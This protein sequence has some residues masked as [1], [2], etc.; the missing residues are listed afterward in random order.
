MRLLPLDHQY[1][2]NM[3]TKYLARAN[4]DPRHD[5]GDY[6]VGD[7]RA[8]FC[9]TW[10]FPIV[11]SYSDGVDAAAGYALNR[12]TFVYHA[13]ASQNASVSVIGT[14]ATLSAPIPLERI[15]C[16]GLA[17]PYWA[18]TVAVPKGGEYTY[19]YL[20]DGAPTLDPINPQR[21]TL[22]NG[23]EWSRFF[24][25][26]CTRRVTFERWEAVLLTRLTEHILPFRTRDGQRFID[27][28][29]SDLDRSAKDVQFAHAY[30]L[31]QNVGVVNFLDKAL[32]REESHHVADYRICLREVDRL[33]RQRNPF[34]D[35]GEMPREMF[36]DL[37]D[38]MAANRVAGW[39]YGRYQNPRYFLQLLR[40][41]C[42]TG[43]FAHPKYGG[44]AGGTGWA[45]LEDRYRDAAGATLFAW[46]ESIE[47][48][49]G[50][51]AEYRG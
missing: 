31:E 2:L 1:V 42:I 4:V 3:S 34:V 37:Y 43:A 32:A 38:E 12:V 46:R 9:E 16:D 6:A 33:L 10:R 50:D 45:Y 5:Y 21:R 40:R 29:Y 47:Q 48:P 24:T 15:V 27:L 36:V 28:Y 49:L 8:R 41:H 51:S 17:T 13:F 7:P 18:V 25:Q 44:N 35:P 39:D 19:Q 11:D 26:L 23:R 30:R 20:V 14:F 22:D